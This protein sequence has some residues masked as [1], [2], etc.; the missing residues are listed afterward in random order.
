MCFI[1]YSHFLIDHLYWAFVLSAM[2]GM[3]IAHSG[4]TSAI[5]LL[6]LIVS[7]SV[8]YDRKTNRLD[9]IVLFFIIYSIITYFFNFD[10][11]FGLFIQSARDQIIP[12]CFYFIARSNSFKNCRMLENMIY[13]LGF[14]YLAGLYFYFFQPSWYMSFKLDGKDVWN[15]TNYYEILRLSSFWW[16]SYFVGYSSLIVIIY[17]LNQRFFNG[18]VRKYYNCILIVSLFVIFFAQQRVSIAFLFLYLIGLYFVLIKRNRISFIKTLPYMLLTG[19]L[20]ISVGGYL[21]LNLDQDLITY[22]MDRSINKDDN[23]I[24]ERTKMFDS[25]L[26][27]ISF[28]GGGLGKYSHNA[29]KYDMDSI[30]DCEYIRLPN[31]LGI[32]GSFIFFIIIFISFISIFKRNRFYG[33]EMLVISFVLIAMVG[34]APLEMAS[35]HPILLWYCIG[36]T[37]MKEYYDRC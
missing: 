18:V 35:Q 13:P 23:L 3:I 33:F 2:L 10:Y 16:H 17:I 5:Y 19:L 27:T 12:I 11:P 14:A 28:F 1:R 4:I 6:C 15:A 36:R 20:I 9:L 21:L 25:Y 37:Q 7:L 30:A 34:A 31:E 29:I 26:K 24:E 8:Y 22:I 32:F